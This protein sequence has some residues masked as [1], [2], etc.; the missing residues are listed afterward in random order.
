MHGSDRMPHSG[1][2]MW[3]RSYARLRLED[4]TPVVY[5]DFGRISQFRSSSQ[6]W[7]Y[8]L[9]PVTHHDSGQWVRRLSYHI[10]CER[11]CMAGLNDCIILQPGHLVENRLWGMHDSIS[12][13][14]LISHSFAC[15]SSQVVCCATKDLL[16]C[17]NMRKIWVSGG[18]KCP[19]TLENQG[20]RMSGQTST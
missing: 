10:S 11:L 1:W 12:V 6:L 7:T 18:T 16:A 5:P 8:L 13:Q 14:N 2:R 4:M 15:E 19:T 20:L 9:T 3:F 17:H